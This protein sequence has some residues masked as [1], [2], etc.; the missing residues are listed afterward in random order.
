MSETQTRLQGIIVVDA[1]DSHSGFTI[2]PS[3]PS[4]PKY[5]YRNCV[6]NLRAREVSGNEPRGLASREFG[7]DITWRVSRVSD[8]GANRR[9]GGS[10]GFDGPEKRRDASCTPQCE[11]AVRQ[12]CAARFHVPRS[13][14]RSCLLLLLTSLPFPPS[15][16]LYLPVCP[17]SLAHCRDL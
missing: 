4:T 12:E 5:R 14:S 7:S 2:A 3:P 13:A 16:S 9:R 11:G 17:S 1:N 15:I 10:R 8:R 6:E